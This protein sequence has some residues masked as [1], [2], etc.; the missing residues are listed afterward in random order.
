M[1]DIQCTCFQ[2]HDFETLSFENVKEISDE[3]LTLFWN[4]DPGLKVI[5]KIKIANITT[6]NSETVTQ[7]WHIP[8]ANAVG[9]FHTFCMKL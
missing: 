6:L 4:N 2:E 7:G 5:N 8:F 1:N 3:I 9:Y